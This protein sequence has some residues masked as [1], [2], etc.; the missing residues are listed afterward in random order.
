MGQPAA[1]SSYPMLG[2]LETC[3][4][5]G[6]T[7][8]WRGA[9]LS[10]ASSLLRAEHLTSRPAYREELPTP[11]NCFT[12]KKNSCSSFSCLPTSF[13]LNVGQKL[14]QRHCG[15]RGF[16]PEHQHPEDPVTQ[17]LSDHL[18]QY[19]HVLYQLCHYLVFF[20]LI[21]SFVQITLYQ[22][23]RFLLLV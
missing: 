3:R 17:S 4:D 18:L 20:T 8:V 15:H 7:C 5:A 22:K 14:G 13:F 11:L 2:A 9:T 16:Q 19:G 21:Y 6:M 23:E 12:T 10:W 1:E